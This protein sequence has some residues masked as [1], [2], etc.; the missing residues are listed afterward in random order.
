MNGH[1]KAAR[2]KE[3]IFVVTGYSEKS[4]VS[5]A[6]SRC[7]MEHR[8]SLTPIRSSSSAIGDLPHDGQDSMGRK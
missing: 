5:D 3:A 2:L 7:S 4:S 1:R 8:V 6:F